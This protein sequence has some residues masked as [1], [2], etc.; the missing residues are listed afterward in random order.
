MNN[1]N[2]GRFDGR[3]NGKMAVEEK[4]INF[5]VRIHPSLKVALKEEVERLNKL[6][7]NSNK[8]TISGLANSALE[9]IFLKPAD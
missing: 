2:Q 3:G 5:M 8:V 4:K 9:T 7:K 1:M 6:A